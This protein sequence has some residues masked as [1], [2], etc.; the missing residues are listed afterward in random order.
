MELRLTAD[1]F[2]TG[3]FSAL[4]LKNWS[5]ISLRNDQFDAAVADVFSLLQTIAKKENYNLRFRVRLHP[6][7]SDSSTV[8]DSVT[9]AIKRNLISLD[10]PMFQDIRL[11]MSKMEAQSY[12]TTLPGGAELFFKLADE[13]CRQFYAFAQQHHET[14]SSKGIQKRD[15]AVHKRATR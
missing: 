12:L 2:F 11:K 7:H 3:L 6:L 5:V 10:N 4:A 9:S 14:T 8:R 13:F 15:R 1:D